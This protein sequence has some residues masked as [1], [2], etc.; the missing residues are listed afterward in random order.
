[1]R[2]S[3]KPR[4]E[5]QRAR[6]AHLGSWVMGRFSQRSIRGHIQGGYV[7]LCRTYAAKASKKHVSARD[8]PPWVS[9]HRDD[10]PGGGK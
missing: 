5:T 10:A 9:P 7:E 4:R 6:G 2:S 3:R 8:S 1:M